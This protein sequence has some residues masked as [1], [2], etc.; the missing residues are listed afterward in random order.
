[1]GVAAGSKGTQFHRLQRFCGG[2]LHHDVVAISDRVPFDDAP[3][4]LQ[5]IRLCNL[6]IRPRRAQVM[7][8]RDAGCCRRACVVAS[9]A[10][11][12]G[13]EV[14]GCSAI[15]KVAVPIGR[16]HLEHSMPTETPP[17]KVNPGWQ[18][19]FLLTESLVNKRSEHSI[20]YRI[21]S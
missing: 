6:E 13:I 12:E 17:R 5:S 16:I 15:G 18:G 9:P 7:P 21:P 3:E 8:L 2:D 19:D 1:M 10:N 20:L 4:T 14:L 11:V